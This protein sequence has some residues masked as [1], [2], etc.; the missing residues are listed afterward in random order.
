MNLPEQVRST[1]TLKEHIFAS[2]QKMQ[3]LVRKDRTGLQDIAL[4][5]SWLKESSD[6]WP[7]ALWA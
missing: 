6:L 1:S 2:A 3:A 7:Q 5:H 4:L